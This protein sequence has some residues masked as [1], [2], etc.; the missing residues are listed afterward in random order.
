MANA[1]AQKNRR[2]EINKQ[3][4]DWEDVARFVISQAA[5]GIHYRTIQEAEIEYRR[6]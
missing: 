3:P 2:K 4:A 5:K 6:Q 1:K